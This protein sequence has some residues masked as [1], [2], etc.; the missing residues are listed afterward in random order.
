MGNEFFIR[1]DVFGKTKYW[2]F[3]DGLHSGKGKARGYSMY[4]SIRSAKCEIKKL[5]KLFHGGIRFSILHESEIPFIKKQILAGKRN[6]RICTYCGAS[7][8]AKKKH[9]KK[10]RKYQG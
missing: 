4:P 7:N 1:A 5:R 2:N 6:E 3:I 10:C 9:C 8:N